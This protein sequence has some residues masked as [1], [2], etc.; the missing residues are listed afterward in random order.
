MKHH[1][2][3]LS[4][5]LL[6]ISNLIHGARPSTPLSAQGTHK[7][8]HDV[9]C[10]YTDAWCIGCA[11]LMR[12]T[13]Y[14]YGG[15]Q[16]SSSNDDEDEKMPMTNA[17]Y[18]LQLQDNGEQLDDWQQVANHGRSLGA[19]AAFAVSALPDGQGM[20]IVGGW[21]SNSNSQSI[22]YYANSGN[23]RSLYTYPRQSYLT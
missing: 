21:G 22:I 6:C 23:W 16:F 11:L 19:N 7:D 8:F 10:L 3:L 15:A 5:I 9:Y 1:P 2:V 17:M 12:N 14:C 4:F 20:I 13:I 18:S